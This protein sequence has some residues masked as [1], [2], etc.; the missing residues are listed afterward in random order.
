MDRSPWF[1]AQTTE[2]KAM[3]NPLPTPMLWPVPPSCPTPILSMRTPLP[4]V[5]Y[6]LI[7]MSGVG[8]ISYHIATPTGRPPVPTRVFGV[9][10]SPMP[11]A[12]S[13]L[14]ELRAP[15]FSL[16]PGLTWQ[17]NCARHDS[18]A[19][20]LHHQFRDREAGCRRSRRNICADHPGSPRLLS[21]RQSGS[22]LATSR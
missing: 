15:R 12:P 19:R 4:T 22:S 10:I 6:E 7:R 9:P 2:V 20:G 18:P 17:L 5:W 11:I 14:H 13:I 16:G 3:P 1:P 21:R 8:M